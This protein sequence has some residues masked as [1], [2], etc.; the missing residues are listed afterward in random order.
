VPPKH[1]AL[2]LL[3]LAIGFALPPVAALAKPAKGVHDTS[4]AVGGGAI[5]DMLRTWY[6]QGEAAGNIGDFYDNR[7]RG[8][9]RLD[10]TLYPQ[11]KPITY[12]PEQRK[13]GLDW[14]YQ[15]KILPGVVFGNSSTS[16]PPERGGSNVRLYYSI[17]RGLAFLFEEYVHNNLYIYPEHR[18]HDPG[19]NGT[20]GYGDLYPTNTPYLIASQGSSGSDQVFMRAIAYVL[21]A[22]R[23]EVKR[24]LIATGL[25]MPTI[26]MLLRITGKQLTGPDPYLT[27]KAHPTVFE[28]SRVDAKKMVEMAHDITLKAIPPLALI[29]VIDQ[30][31]PKEGLDYFEPG[32]TEVLADTP[33][34]IARIFRGKAYWRKMVVSAKSSVDVNHRPLAFH[35]A[36]LRGDPAKVCIHRLN[37]E[38]SMAEIRVAY[39]RR[40]PIAKAASLESNRVDIGVFVNNGVYFSPPA[41]VT[42]YTL[43]SESRTYTPDGRIEEIAYGAGTSTVSV[44]D[45]TT[46]FQAI[47][48]RADGAQALL[49][50]R[51]SPDQQ[52]ALAKTANAYQT[53]HEATVDAKTQLDRLAAA[54]TLA[55]KAL[56]R[57]R[58]SAGNAEKTLT[59]SPS[60][61]HRKTLDQARAN[62]AEAQKTHQSVSADLRVKRQA[63]ETAQNLET[64]VLTKPMPA[65]NIGTAAFVQRAIDALMQDPDLLPG[66]DRLFQALYANASA[67]AKEAF[68]ALR[69]HLA[70]FGLCGKSSKGPIRWTPAWAG[71]AKAV[72]FTDY[73]KEMIQRL[74]A[75]AMRLLLFPKM[76]SASW[77]LNYVDPR[78]TSAKH[79]RDVYRYAPD[80]TL[81]GWK[82]Y[83]GK[84]IVAFRA[85]GTRI[86]P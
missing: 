10:L 14:A 27:G 71:Q 85:D 49:K 70:D 18:D 67:P 53:A 44:S 26:Q 11:L 78:L 77:R 12:T 3:A 86:E 72:H 68:D 34:V 46:L 40:Q 1:R 66:H 22:F 41:F 42:F 24:K 33:A 64:Q 61:A 51:F 65:L 55:A 47:A 74:N 6:A 17:E 25:L 5:G 30:D 48:S 4:I 84:T 56:K 83:D 81:S 38:G 36:L 57:A 29:R 28:G 20:G 60:L 7:D 59:S 80:K 50:N 31:L 39:Q 82:R 69:N 62:L 19:H 16:A 79:W 13:Q 21:A 9:S 75:A 35:W 23:P 76:I 52:A 63:F 15:K 45:W 58:A 54:Q 43:D 37:A 32:K 2:A 8:H 73:E